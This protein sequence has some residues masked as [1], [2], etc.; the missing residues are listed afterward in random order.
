MIGNCY[1][2]CVASVLEL[3]LK[4]VPN[5]AS[6]LADN[7]SEGAWNEA[8]NEWSRERGFYILT[9]TA[10]K[11]PEEDF[12]AKGEILQGIHHLIGGKARADDGSLV[13]HSVV[14]LNGKM[15]WDPNQKRNNG[16]E[17]VEDYSVFVP[18]DPAT[19]VRKRSRF[20]T[21]TEF[22]PFSI[23]EAE[24]VLFVQL[25]D[26]ELE[27]IVL[28][29]GSVSAYTIAKMIEQSVSGLEAFDDGYGRVVVGCDLETSFSIAPSKAAETL[30]L[31]PGKYGVF[32]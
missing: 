25:V 31:K 20:A 14:G 7:Y 2:A 32:P 24:E 22:D 19:L 10:P 30:G 17:I 5:W 6:L 1:T 13:N 18:L 26:K 4:D 21:G 8:I 15:V 3:P 28:P 27:V 9:T 29:T 11:D 23:E 12:V 16:L